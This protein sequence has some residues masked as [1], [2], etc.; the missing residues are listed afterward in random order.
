MSLAR[1]VATWF[2]CG[3]SPLAPGTV[4][5]LGTLPLW[6]FLSRAGTPLYWLVTLVLTV[7]GVWASEQTA[8]ELG[9]D[10]PGSVVI[11]EVV[12]TLL[13]LGLGG[14]GLVANV[15]AFV[16]FRAFDIKKPWLID[17]VQYLRPA[18]V[19]IMADDVLA[20]VAAGALVRLAVTFFG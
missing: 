8:R 10:D 15:S 9:D 1:F 16:L 2:G 5:S 18:G 6:W 20:G 3:L 13:A 12:G 4:G 19:G 7:I 11:D 17:R 14:G